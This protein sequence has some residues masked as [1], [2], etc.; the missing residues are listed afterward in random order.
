MVEIADVKPAW[1]TW[2]PSVFVELPAA[3]L[4]RN[5]EGGETVESSSSRTGPTPKVYKRFGR[6]L[7]FSFSD[8]YEGGGVKNSKIC[9][10]FL[11][12]SV[13]H[14]QRW[15]NV[16]EIRNKLS[17]C[18]WYVFSKSGVIQCPSLRNWGDYSS[19]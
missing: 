4:M 9:S 17:K 13:T 5:S 19:L 3:S 1:S 10:K 6:R 2:F 12:I 14:V 16:C 8:F 7:S 11:A 18:Q 15:S